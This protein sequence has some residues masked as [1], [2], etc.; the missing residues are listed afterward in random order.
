MTSDDV[1]TL[2]PGAVPGL[3]RN[4]N[5]HR[6]WLAQAVSLTGDSIFEVTVML[7][8]ASVIAKG[9]VWAPTAASGVLIAAAVPVLAVG[10]I[11]GV[12]IDRWDRRQI[13]MAADACR[14]ILIATLVVVPVLGRQVPTAVALGATYVAVAM[15]SGFAQFFNPSRLAL[16][17]LLVAVKDRPHASSMLQATSSTASIIGPPLA[18]PLLFAAGVQW[19]LVIDAISFAISFAAIRSIKVSTTQRMPEASQ[20]A[21]FRADFRTGLQFFATNRILVALTTGVVI[22]TLGTGALNALSVFF[23]RD[24][25]HA[26]PG[27]LGTLYA[28]ISIGA[29]GGALLC[30]RAVR[31]IGAA[32]VFWLAM[33]LGGLLLLAY[34]R[35]TELPPAL[36]IVALVGCV[37]GA[38]NAAAPP[39]LLA[40][41]PQQIMGR[42]MSVFNTLQQA[43]NIISMAVAGFLAGTT[44]RGMHVAAGDLR[45]GP[46]DTIFGVSAVL[47]VA[48]GLAMIKPLSG[49]IAGSQDS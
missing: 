25:L 44:L 28:A 32:R 1:D 7:W 48:G 15:E 26:A 22:C 27:W 14:A 10:P 43:A 39:L 2:M 47:I 49:P 33:V 34:S 4:R 37:F 5:W 9:Q 3:R 46:I 12:W 23:L 13:M 29:I 21:G 41:I 31:R 20:R 8:V 30:A 18:A 17:G 40:L 24:N 19:A 38:L 6:L 16:L 45:F 11:A 35:L 42:T 36:V